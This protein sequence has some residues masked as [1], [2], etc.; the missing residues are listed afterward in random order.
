MGHH[1]CSSPTRKS[2][3]LL[4]LKNVHIVSKETL[5]QQVPRRT[6]VSFSLIKNILMHWQTSAKLVICIFQAFAMVRFA[7]NKTRVANLN[8]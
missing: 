2:N 5:P 7:A 6:L 8:F 4:T 3:F 1:S